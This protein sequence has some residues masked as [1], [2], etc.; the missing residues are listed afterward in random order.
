[1]IEVIECLL[2]SARVGSSRTPAGTS[3]G[4]R[5][6]SRRAAR[7]RRGAQSGILS[8][9]AP[10]PAP[11]AHTAYHDPW[12]RPRSCLRDV[13]QPD[14][15]VSELEEHGAVVRIGGGRRAEVPGRGP[16]VAPAQIRVARIRASTGWRS[17][18][19]PVSRSTSRSS[20]R[21]AAILPGPLAPRDR[22]PVEDSAST[23]H[24]RSSGAGEGPRPA[25]GGRAGRLGPPGRNPPGS[26]RLRWGPTTPPGCCS[27][28]ASD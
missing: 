25:S 14:Q 20:P 4:P 7:R 9:W 8:R 3:S 2:T 28:A 18:S 22:R 11:A 26:K 10:R 23:S 5:P 27:R 12:T 15:G 24:H 1:M 16:Q 19:S 21:A 17:A 6:A 13:A